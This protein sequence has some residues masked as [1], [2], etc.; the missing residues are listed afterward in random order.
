MLNILLMIILIIILFILI[1]LYL[2]VRISLIYEKKGS[3]LK[4]C[5]KILILRKIKVYST[6]YPSEDEDEE[7]DDDEEQEKHDVKKMIDLALPCFEYFKE[8]LK[9][10]TKCIHVSKLENHLIFGL[11]SYVSTAKYIGYIWSLLIIINSSHENARFTAEPSFNGS[12]IDIKGENNID[13]NLL[14]IIV[15]SIK[16]I[17]KKEV[18]QLIKGVRNG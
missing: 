3:K 15:P 2:G 14:K 17:S 13:I 16:L 6:H 10:F 4:G 8:F 7:E 5:L 12:V 18:R 11:D 1:L 9:S